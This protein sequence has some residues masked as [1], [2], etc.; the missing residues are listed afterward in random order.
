MAFFKK[1][2]KDRR[3]YSAPEAGPVSRLAVGFVVILRQ[4]TIELSAC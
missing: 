2:G 4:Q 3:Q 1:K